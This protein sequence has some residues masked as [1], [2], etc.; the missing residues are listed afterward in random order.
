MILYLHLCVI[1]MTTQTKA[2]LIL[3]E[4]YYG[5][6]IVTD[7][8]SFYELFDVKGSTITLKNIEWHCMS[9]GFDTWC[10]SWSAVHARGGIPKGELE[11]QYIITHI[12]YLKI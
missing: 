6:L 4:Q 10:Q 12:Y 5:P 7:Y 8:T 2:I 1:K 9:G 3:N 11:E